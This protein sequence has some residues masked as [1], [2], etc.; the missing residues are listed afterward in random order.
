MLLQKIL[1][2]IIILTNEV[3]CFEYID[4]SNNVQGKYNSYGF[5]GIS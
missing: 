2:D 4:Y 5:N 1:H 3:L